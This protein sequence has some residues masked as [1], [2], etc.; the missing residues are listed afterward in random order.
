M[1]R[2]QAGVGRAV[3][4]A[5]TV[6]ALALPRA[7]AAQ[8]D[9]YALIIEG[10]SGE[11]QYA[12]LHRAW[13]DDLVKVLRDDFKYDAAHLVVLAETPKAGEERSTGENVKAAMA[14]LAKSVKAQDQ[15]FVM[16]IGH[17][18]A[19]A[20]GAKFNLIGPDLAVADWAAL[21]KPIPGRIAVV[22][23][24]AGSFPFLAGLAGQNR[25]VITATSRTAQVFHSRFAEGFVS[26]LKTAA[27]DSDKNGRI[28]LLEAFNYA[29]RQVALH[30]EQAGTKQTEQAM[31]DD[32]GDGVGI[33]S[34]PPAAA[35]AATDGTAAGLMYLDAMAMPK[36]NDP[37][38]QQLLVRQQTLM[39]QVDDL[40]RKRPSMPAEEFDREFE[41]VIID[42]A[43]VSR[44]VRKRTG[45]QEP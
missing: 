24:T 40:R 13:L 43:L 23:A 25:V 5:V 22:D 17:G 35:A 29:S 34:G 33:Q 44:D 38:V 32:T 30:Y 26:S 42:L 15:L 20:T 7:A 6:A 37:E 8:G 1:R 27:A 21:L 41:K 28:S 12:Q 3:L 31:L 39:Q 10:A 9:R 45:G 18:T 11:P 2:L 19:D 16:F 4:L 14:R 36:S